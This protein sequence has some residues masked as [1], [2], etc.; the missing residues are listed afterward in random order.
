MTRTLITL[1]RTL[2][3]RALHS[4]PQQFILAFLIGFYGLLGLVSLSLAG[5]MDFADATHSFHVLTVINGLGVAMY[6][7]LSVMM[8]AGEKQ[9]TPAELGTFPL[10]YREVRPALAWSLFLTTRSIIATLFTVIFAVGGAVFL[11]TH[12]RPL[13]AAA[14]VVSMAFSLALTVF[15][16]DLVGALGSA[17]LSKDKAN[18]VMGLGGVAL[19]FLFTNLQGILNNVAPLGTV[20][21]VLAWTPLSALTG[22]VA[23]LADGALAPA[24]AQL[25][26]GLVTLALVAWGWDLTA[27]HTFESPV[28]G[29][30]PST[31][32]RAEGVTALSLGGLA[33]RSPA[34]M[35]YSRSLRYFFRD[36]RLT[37]TL[38]ML[39]VF[40]AFA[41]YQLWRGEEFL[42]YFFV[43][44]LGLLGGIVAINDFG[45]DGPSLRVKMLAPV[46]ASFLFRARHWAHLTATV[47]VM[48]LGVVVLLL[49]APDRAFAAC[50]AA[51]AVGM[52]LSSGS[53]A[54]LLSAFN[55]YP[56]SPPGTNPWTDK[57]GYST[58]AFIAAIVCFFFGWLPVAPGI[59]MVILGADSGLKFAGAAVGLVVPAAIYVLAL[60]LASRR[61]D[62]Q[63]PEIYAKV[64]TYVS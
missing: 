50:I 21:G 20:G 5:Y 6:I 41:F 39:P 43:G 1:H 60:W 25:L 22:W 7:L 9:L 4:N 31:A 52:V 34:W 45:Y 16:A 57:S 3:T 13:L 28:H 11:T 62:A 15:A 2:W 37:M 29:N 8:P 30:A 18:L 55:P 49:L 27:R 26:I 44:C 56:V 48:A 23:S 63:M 17:A 40:L 33:Y 51:L 53:F 24:L 59:I 19:L 38:V 58:G 35:E 32:P 42:G 12:G 61:V 46:R 64:R 47:V 36:S 14:F 10:S 54:A